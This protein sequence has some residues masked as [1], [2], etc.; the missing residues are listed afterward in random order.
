MS[1]DL[2]GAPVLPAPRTSYVRLRTGARRAITSSPSARWRVSRVGGDDDRKSILLAEREGVGLRGRQ[3]GDVPAAF[4]G[5][6]L[7][8]NR[9][10]DDVPRELAE[11]EPLPTG[12][13]GGRRAANQEQKPDHRAATAPGA[14][15]G[16]VVLE[17]S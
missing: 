15:P 9:R 7:A 16:A 6:P 5:L 11:S 1:S 14:Q 2:R 17:A 13:R 12:G 10:R 8:K 3:Q 4:V